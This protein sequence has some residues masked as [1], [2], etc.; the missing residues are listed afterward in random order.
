MSDDFYDKLRERLSMLDGHILTYDEVMQWPEGK[1]DELMQ[2]GKVREGST[3]ETV[4]C[5]ECPERCPIAP[6]VR[7]HPG[8]GELIGVY[9]CPHDEDI[10]RFTVDMNR[11]KR[12]ELV[13]KKP[14]ARK[15]RKKTTI[16]PDTQKAA[17]SFA[18]WNNP[19]EAC[20]VLDEDRIKFWNGDELKD[21]RLKSGSRSHMLLPMLQEGQ[22][23]NAE[24]KKA[25]CSDKTSPYDAVRDVN[26]TLND[27]IKKLNIQD[28][29]SNVEF[30]GRDDRTGLYYSFL[31]IT[32]WHDF[33]S[34]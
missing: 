6:D 33:E 22:M 3:S 10:G 17:T 28:V 9:V 19:G 30:I 1:L 16:V 23:S 15:K 27:K 32:P 13:V 5:V 18:R 2:Q 25:I 29:P 21:L 12:W 31:P 7:Q 26:R 34:R 24:V 11:R 14:K 20:F 8:T 4:V